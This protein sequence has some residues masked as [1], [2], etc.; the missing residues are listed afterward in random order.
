MKVDPNSGKPHIALAN[1][2]QSAATECLNT[3]LEGKPTIDVKLVFKMAY[4]EY[5]KA[6]KDPAYAGEAKAKMKWLRSS[7]LIPTK[8]DK[9]LHPDVKTPR[10][11]CF[12]WI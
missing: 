10:G 1:V 7:Q 12:S 9:F 11:K 8:E 5:S 6:S 4:N 3:K 2:Y